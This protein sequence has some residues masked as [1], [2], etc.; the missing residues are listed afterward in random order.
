MQYTK[1]PITVEAWRWLFTPEQDEPPV[2]MN[3]ALNHWPDI[4]GAAFEPYHADGPRISIATLE[5]VMVARPGDFIIQGVKGEIYPCKPDVFEMSYDPKIETTM[6]PKDICLACSRPTT[7]DK[8]R[9]RRFEQ[10][11]ESRHGS[12]LVHFTITVHVDLD[13]GLLCPSCLMEVCGDIK[14]AADRIEKALIQ[15]RSGAKQSS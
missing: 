4:G 10:S 12:A 6:E 15:R 1:K 14:G 7:H 11:V 8:S 9:P 5:G 13:L 3:D 2:W